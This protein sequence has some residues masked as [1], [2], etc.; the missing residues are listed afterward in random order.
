MRDNRICPTCKGRLP[1]WNQR[2]AVRTR[3][4]LNEPSHTVD[5]TESYIQEI[6]DTNMDGDSHR[7]TNV[8]DGH[9][10]PASGEGEVKPLG[11]D[12]IGVVENEPQKNERGGVS[13][14]M[15]EGDG[16][17]LPGMIIIRNDHHCEGNQPNDSRGA[18]M[19]NPNRTPEKSEP[20]G[21]NATESSP[22]IKSAFCQC[23][24]QFQ[25][26]DC[27]DRNQRLLPDTANP[28][29][30]I[31]GESNRYFIGI[32]DVFTQFKLKKKMEYLY[33]CLRYPTQSFSTV[34]PEHYAERFRDFCSAKTE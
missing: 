26:D 3:Q 10:C 12:N 15:G 13:T 25:T 22:E 28:L 4:T 24:K 5:K 18:S 6:L 8:S 1:T 17:V 16:H 31:D 11:G 29:H 32:I 23:A 27:V 20:S 2:S 14:K 21:R 19:L 9:H 30:I 34:G 33:K 7:Y